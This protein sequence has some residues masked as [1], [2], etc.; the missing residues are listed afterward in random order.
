MALV[1]IEGTGLVAELVLDRPEKL[2]AFS[3]ELFADFAAAL[4]TVTRDQDVSVIIVRGEGRA[5]SVGWD[6]GPS[7]EPQDSTARHGAYEDWMRLRHDLGVFTSVFDCPK[8]VVA[9]V[10]GY[11]M[12]GATVLAISSDLTVVGD[13]TRIGWPVLPLG[14]GM[15]GPASMWL[16]GPKK[17]K[18]LSYIAGSHLTGPEAASLGWANYSVPEDQVL[19]KSRSL[20][21]EI[22][23][24]PSDMLLI[25]K[26]ATNRV[27]AMQGFREAIQY[28]AEWDALSHTAP[29]N[30][31]MSRKVRDVGLREAIRW[32]DEGAA[33]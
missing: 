7:R 3:P 5:F 14:G 30:V 11:C 31:Q 25:K 20:A 18:E 12:G 17:A 10:H 8:P 23:K 4:D 32:F 15:L 19:S 6:L 16:I 9:S 29:G 24:T 26:L 27:L 21:A 1:R 22:A 28:G 2:N 33:D 13:E